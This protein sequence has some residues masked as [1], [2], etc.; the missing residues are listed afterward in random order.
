MMAAMSSFGTNEK[1][2]AHHGYGCRPPHCRRP[3]VYV[4]KRCGT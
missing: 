2:A 1:F 4:G 3:G